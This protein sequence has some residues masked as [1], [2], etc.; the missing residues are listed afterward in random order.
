MKEKRNDKGMQC[1]HCGYVNEPEESSDYD[2]DST[3]HWCG[4]C[5]TEF[6]ARCYVT[7]TWISKIPD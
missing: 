7:H 5:G 6:E 3:T 1:P 2:E 4:D